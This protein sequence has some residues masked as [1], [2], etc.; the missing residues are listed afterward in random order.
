ML[1]RVAGWLIVA[2]CHG[3]HPPYQAQKLAVTVGVLP[4]VGKLDV[5][6]QLFFVGKMD[7]GHKL[8]GVEARSDPLPVQVTLPIS[9]MTV[10]AGIQ[11][12]GQGGKPLDQSAMMPFENL[13]ERVRG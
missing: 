5:I 11:R 7:L 1:R 13:K 10:A 6:H 12:V 2:R 3:R 9:P 4:T 8:E